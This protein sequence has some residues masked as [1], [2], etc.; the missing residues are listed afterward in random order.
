MRFYLY[1]GGR[2]LVAGVEVI[3]DE[4]LK[5]GDE[6]TG[7]SNAPLRSTVEVVHILASGDNEQHMIVV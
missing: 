2:E 4:P 1:D 3:H 6:I 5:I 7:V